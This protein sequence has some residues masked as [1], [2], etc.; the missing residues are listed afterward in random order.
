MST[1][2][3]CTTVLPVIHRLF[4]PRNCADYIGASQMFIGLSKERPIL[5]DHP[6]THILD[7]MKFGG[8]HVKSAGFHA[9]FR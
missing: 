2:F 6:K 5:G 8:F 1:W 4:L 3:R 7:F 9:D